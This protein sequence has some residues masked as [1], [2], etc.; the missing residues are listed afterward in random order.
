MEDNIIGI[1]YNAE[2]H[3]TWYQKELELKPDSSDY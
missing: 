1:K 3:K 2:D